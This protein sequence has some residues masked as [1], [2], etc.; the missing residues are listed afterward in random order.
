[1]KEQLK[2]IFTEN[3]DCYSTMV[4]QD[5][6][7]SDKFIEVVSDLINEKNHIKVSEKETYNELRVKSLT[8]S[9]F[10]VG[11]Q[12]S[13]SHKDIAPLTVYNNWIKETF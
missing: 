7:T 3:A 11:L 2:Q 5:A 10:L 13:Q 4:M 8:Y 1:M 6:M 12:A 9:A